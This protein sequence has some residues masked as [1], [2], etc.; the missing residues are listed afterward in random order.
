MS[1]KQP[2]RQ[3]QK[4]DPKK[5]YLDI[6]YR[7][8]MIN[9]P[10]VFNAIYDINDSKSEETAILVDRLGKFAFDF[11]GTAREKQVMTDSR[12]SSNLY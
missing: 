4:E 3:E 10:N 9:Q 2:E 11:Q 12:C 7:A 1:D 5:K 6:L 8:K